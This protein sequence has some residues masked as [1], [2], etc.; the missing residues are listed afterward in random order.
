LQP[1]NFPFSKSIRIFFP[2]EKGKLK[3]LEQIQNLIF[4]ENP[5]GSIFA[6]HFSDQKLFPEKIK[7]LNIP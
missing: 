5:F 3:D 4:F 6:N 2:L 1:C 7:L